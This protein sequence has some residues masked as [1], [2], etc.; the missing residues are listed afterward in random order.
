M[1]RVF[2]NDMNMPEYA[3]A[4]SPPFF[5]LPIR[6]YLSSDQKEVED[7]MKDSIFVLIV[8]LYFNDLR[9]SNFFSFD[10]TSTGKSISFFL[11]C[12]P[13]SIPVSVEIRSFFGVVP[14][15]HMQTADSRLNAACSSGLVG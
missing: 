6:A 10:L 12:S 15:V 4:H 9:V 3:R 1:R 8:F 13:M 14:H 7:G 11:S 2:K 5:P